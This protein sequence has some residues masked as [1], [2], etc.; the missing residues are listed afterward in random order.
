VN[1]RKRFV[2]PVDIPEFAALMP[3]RLLSKG[4]CCVGNWT[5]MG[6]ATLRKMLW[7]FL[8]SNVGVRLDHLVA[9]DPDSPDAAI[10]LGNLE[11]TGKL[12]PTVCWHSASGR[13]TRLY[14]P[15]PG[16]RVQPMAPSQNALHL[17][18]RCGRT[19]QCLIPPSVVK[20][21]ENKDAPIELREYRWHRDPWQVEIAELPLETWQIIQGLAR[22]KPDRTPARPL[23]K[24]S[25]QASKAPASTGKILAGER[26]GFLFSRARA[27][28]GRGADLPEILRELEKL[29][30]ERCRPPL[31]SEE[32]IRIAKSAASYPVNSK[33]DLTMLALTYEEVTAA[34]EDLGGR[35]RWI[36]RA[37][38]IKRLQEMA[39]PR[40]I[41]NSPASPTT[42]K[43]VLKR[44]TTMRPRLLSHR[45]GGWYKI[46]EIP[47]GAKG[48]GD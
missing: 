37:A 33:P 45:E 31:G 2:L 27:M 12:P 42:V 39:G 1:S 44:M 40:T 18:V 38:L 5:K 21:Q 43:R 14:K 22:P 34:L 48:K 32:V 13:L 28:R 15:P 46:R 35:E 16:V 20:S 4:H 7:R 19:Q 47:T 41:V 36:R 17:E 3:I 30:R 24:A 11:L 25:K 29:N 6:H 8:G 9:L 26:N 23:T 10:F